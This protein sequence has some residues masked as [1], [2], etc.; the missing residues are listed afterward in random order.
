MNKPILT[1]VLAAFL[2]LTLYVLWQ[3]GLLNLFV[4]NLNHPAGVQV[5]VDLAIMLGLFC[6]W[7]WRDARAT[8]RNPWLWTAL[9]FGLGSF[10]PLLYL[11]TRKTAA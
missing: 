3:V 1:A 8:G 11:I 4:H 9:S 2:A 10:G 6:A 5:F 7:M